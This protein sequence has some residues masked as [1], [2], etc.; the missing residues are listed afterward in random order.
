MRKN[1]LVAG[2]TL[3]ALALLFGVSDSTGL[4]F[5]IPISILN[6]ILGLVTRAPPGLEIQPESARIKLVIDRGVVGASIYQLVFL[7]SK[8]I[9]KRLS[10][11]MVTVILAFVLAVVGLESLFIVG[12]LMGGISGFSLQEFL[13]QRIRNKIGSEM[14]LTSVG[15]NDIEIEY[16]DILEV[17]LV[18]SRLYLIA[19]IKSLSASFPRGYARKIE[20]MLTNIFESKFTTEES[21]RAAEAAEKENE[22]R[23]H[24]GGDRGKFPRR[25]NSVGFYE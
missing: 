25:K 1:I 14:E 13:T 4:F 23:Q 7:N 3:L 19:G 22:K 17:R 18:K 11:V 5:S 20:P 24:P 2:I 6:I 16:G 15:K 10:S 12:A 8:L 21:I 9:L